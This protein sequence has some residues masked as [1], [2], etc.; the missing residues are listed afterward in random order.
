MDHQ[1][2]HAPEDGIVQFVVG[3]GGT[4]LRSFSGSQPANS[5]V[6]NAN[7]HGILRLRL[8]ASEYDWEFLPIAGSTFSDWGTA[9]CH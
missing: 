1:G 3:T 9:S 4:S 2:N 5:V 8:R 6:R 7:T